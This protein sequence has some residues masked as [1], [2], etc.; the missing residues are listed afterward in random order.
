MHKKYISGLYQIKSLKGL[1]T[2][3]LSPKQGV[4][5][6]GDYF[7]IPGSYPVYL[8]K[9]QKLFSHVYLKILKYDPYF[10]CLD[11]EKTG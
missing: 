10:V 8:F 4:L 6:V 7:K 3:D 5:T 1:Q 11:K 9:H 2:S